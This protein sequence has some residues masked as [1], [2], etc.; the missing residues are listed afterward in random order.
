MYNF[1]MYENS[2]PKRKGKR[3]ENKM[4]TR[5]VCKPNSI[6]S[7]CTLTSIHFCSE[8]F[9]SHVRSNA[10]HPDIQHPPG[11]HCEQTTIALQYV[12]QLPD[13]IGWK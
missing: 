13:H 1:C 11:R 4:T 9:I 6:G 10:C 7:P 12:Y 8:D 3:E 2:L 5:H